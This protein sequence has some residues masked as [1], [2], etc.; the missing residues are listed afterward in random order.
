MAKPDFCFKEHCL[1]EKHAKAEELRKLR[2]HINKLEQKLKQCLSKIKANENKVLR[3]TDL[4]KDT[5]VRQLTGI[6][7]RGAFDKLFFW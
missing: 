5:T 2:D 6:P 1:K 3:Y 7:T 4:R